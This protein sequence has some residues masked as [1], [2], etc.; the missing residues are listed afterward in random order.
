MN[1]AINKNILSGIVGVFLVGVLFGAAIVYAQTISQTHIISAGSYPGAESYTIWTDNAATFYAKNAYGTLEEGADAGVLIQQIVTTVGAAGG[2]DIYIEKGVYEIGAMNLGGE[3]FYYG[4]YVNSPYIRIHGAGRDATVLKLTVG[5]SRLVSFG[6]LASRCELSSLTVDGDNLNVFPSAS[7]A[8]V[9]TAANYDVKVK[10]VFAVN[11]ND[12]DGIGAFEAF[13]FEASGNL[14]ST[15]ALGI[16]LTNTSQSFVHNNHVIDCD[17]TAF[18]IYE[19][20]YDN[21]LTDNYALNAGLYGYEIA[22]YNNFSPSRNTIEGCTATDSATSGLS[23]YASSYNIIDSCHFFDNHFFGVEIDD[24]GVTASSYNILTNIVA[25]DLGS[26]IQPYGIHED[27]LTTGTT[28]TNAVCMGN[29]WAGIST[30]ANSKVSLS[31][32]DTTWLGIYNGTGY[33]P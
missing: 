17:G 13:R 8:L 33:I 27:G 12:A 25:N 32:N 14:V 21:K 7:D 5:N 20:S 6:Y 11:G 1:K 26:A 15:C 31:W 3:G 30:L 19:D 29:T 9:L 10:D 23:I 16:A 18:L 2:G 4:I 28:I 24:D 22:K